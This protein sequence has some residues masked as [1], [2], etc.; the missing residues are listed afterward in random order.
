MRHLIAGNWKMNESPRQARALARQILD[1]LPEQPGADVLLLPPYPALGPVHSVLAEDGRVAM[2]AQNCHWED[3]GAFTGEVSAPMLSD[4]CQY[5]LVGH[6]ERRHLFGETDEQVRAKLEAVLRSG[7]R[8]V[9]ALGE[10]REERDAG[11]TEEVLTRQCRSGMMGLGRDRILRCTVAYEPVWAIGSGAAA[12]PS[13]IADAAAIL[14]SVIEEAASGAA[15]A[16]RILYGGSV[17]ARTAPV[18]LGAEGV[19]GALVGGASL[20]AAEFCGI[21]AAAPAHA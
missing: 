7:M 2:G 6:S 4:W 13:D 3:A 10:T 1:L 8:A 18:L 20:N 19:S 14:R 15:S 11:K 9:L 17:T 5:I 21:V 12:E 16:V